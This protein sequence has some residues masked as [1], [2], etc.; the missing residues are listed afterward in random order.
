MTVQDTLAARTPSSSIS[1]LTTLISTA[2]LRLRSQTKRPFT[3]QV[4]AIG[5]RTSLVLCRHIVGTHTTQLLILDIL[6]VVV[7]DISH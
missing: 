2:R 4:Q 6:T 5:V 1:T 7:P 3:R